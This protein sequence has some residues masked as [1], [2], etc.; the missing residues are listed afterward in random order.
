M[1]A[2]KIRHFYGLF[3]T[4]VADG[5]RS[6][7]LTLARVDEIGRGHI[8][9]GGEALGLGLVD[10]LGGLADAIDEAARL[11][12]APLGRD[13]QPD[14]AVLPPPTSSLAER[15]LG[16]NV[17]AGAGLG[18][19][20]SVAESP[21]AVAA[22]LVKMSDAAPA[23]RLLAPLVAGGGTGIQAAVPYDLEIR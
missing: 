1:V 20:E 4:T 6:R 14:L 17:A 11:S 10:R 18:V 21:A 5:R 15:L 22:R 16:V 23:L 9:T 2:E 13:G 3:L 8:W 19:A 7:G 12:S